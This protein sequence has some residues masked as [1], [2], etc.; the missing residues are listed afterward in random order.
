MDEADTTFRIVLIKIQHSLSNEDRQQLN[1][2]FGDDIPRVLREKGSLADSLNALQALFDRLKISRDNYDYLVQALQ[3]IQRHDCAQR[4]IDYTKFT[5]EIIPPLPNEQ[6]QQNQAETT[7]GSLITKSQVVASEILADLEDEDDNVCVLKTETPSIRF[8]SPEPDPMDFDMIDL[9][10]F[11]NPEYQWTDE[12]LKLL[13]VKKDPRSY[14]IEIIRDSIANGNTVVCLRTGSGKTFIASV[15]I[16]YYFI[17]KQKANPDS[18]F[19]AIFFVPRKAIRLQQA[20]AISEIG[21]LKVQLCED[22]QTIDQLIETNEVIVATPQK[23]LNCLKKGTIDLSKVDLMIFDEC[24]NT[25]GGNPYCE[26]MKFYL[27]PSKNLDPNDRPT[28]IGLT[29]TV[30]AKDTVEK[31]ESIEKNLVSLCSKLACKTIST[32]CNPNNIE[33]INQQIRRPTNDQFEFVLPVEYNPSFHEYLNMFKNLI[34]KI[35]SHLDSNDLLSEQEIGSSGFIGQLVLLQQTFEIK[36]DM[37]NIII[38]EYLLLLTKKYSA[39]KDLPFDM[40]INYISQNIDEYYKGYQQSIPMNNVLY[41]CCKA[42]LN[43]IVK[44]HEEHPTTNSKLDNLVQLLKRHVTG[45]A[46]GLI[47]VKT[48]FYAKTIHD[49]LCKHPELK[50]IVKSTWLVGQNSSDH[51]LTI[52]D[53]EARLK[54]FREDQC[55][56]LVA[57]D[58]VQEGLDIPTCSYVIRYEFVSDEIGTIQSRGRARAQNSSYYLITE[59]DSNNHRREQNNK[60][61][62][63][64]MEMAIKAWPTVDKDIFHRDVESKTKTLIVEWE[65][66]LKTEIQ[67]K[68]ALRKIGKKTGFIRC[69]KCNRNLGALEWLKKRNTTYFINN[70]EFIDNNECRL[71]SEPERRL[72]ILSMGK[73]ICTCGSQLGGCQKFMDRQD[74]G[75]LCALKCDQIK[76]EIE[77]QTAYI[78]FK[79]W[80]KNDRFDVEELEEI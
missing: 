10:I 9:K 5:R 19:L 51:S 68:L 28:V 33:E 4:L 42:E 3:A 31:K 62:E 25:S 53:Q 13:N 35:K 67:Q 1:F 78:E 73:V 43:K 57:T 44:K 59:K 23:F 75:L 54:Q 56:V 26:I 16:K 66:A 36:G 18:K 45:S 48:T 71:R 79:Q 40:V 38:C 46:K 17:K 58:I 69:R 8:S 32:V 61:R 39:L 63:D 15:L 20:K 7:I 50:D 14:Q 37:N 49:Y 11:E 6:H 74:L 70:P 27:C 52:H 2:I 64:N 77:G 60:I 55:N 12:D 21:N 47:L 76:F 34:E 65:N 41:E 24:H 72:E 80:S 22:D 29:A 30:S